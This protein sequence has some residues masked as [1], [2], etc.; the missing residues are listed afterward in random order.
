MSCIYQDKCYRYGVNVD[1]CSEDIISVNDNKAT[2]NQGKCTFCG[3]CFLVC[4]QKTIES[5]SQKPFFGGR[6]FRPGTGS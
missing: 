3:N 1:H 4:P 2:R 6:N 5:N